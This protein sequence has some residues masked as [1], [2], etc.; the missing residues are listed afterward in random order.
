M[1]NRRDFSEVI[2]IRAQGGDAER[3]GKPDSG[4]HQLDR[5]Y[6]LGF[7]SRASFCAS[8]I[9]AGVIMSANSSR[10]FIRS[11]RMSA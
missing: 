11:A 6:L 4:L 3:F 10:R 5:S 2:C 1:R 9:C 8:A 7:H